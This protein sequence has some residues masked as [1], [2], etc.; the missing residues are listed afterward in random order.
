MQ[1]YVILGLEVSIPT[2]LAEIQVPT[3]DKVE[4]SDAH[5]TATP[6]D[7]A[8]SSTRP[9]Q[10]IPSPEKKQEVEEDVKDYW[11]E[12]L[13]SLP[14][15]KQEALKSMGL[16]QLESGSVESSFNDLVAIVNERQKECERKFWRISVRGKTIVLRNYTTS[17]ID[18]F[19]KTGDVAMP[20]APTQIALSWSIVKFVLQIPLYESEQMAALLGTTEKIVRIICRGQAYEKIYLNSK[21]QGPIDP[22]TKNLETGL[23]KIYAKSMRVKLRQAYNLARSRGT[24]FQFE[25]CKEQILESLNIYPRTIVVIYAMDECDSEKRY[26]LIDALKSFILE[27]K[28]TVKIFISS[29]PDSKIKSHLA[30]VPSVTISASNNHDDIEKFLDFELDRFA[31]DKGIRVLGRMKTEIMAKSLE[32]CQGMFQWAAMQVHQLKDCT[33]ATNMREM[34]GNLLDDLKKSYDKIWSQIEALRKPDQTLAKR[35]LRWTMASLRPLKSRELLLI[36]HHHA[37]N[38]FPSHLITFYKEDSTEDSSP[39][40]VSSSKKRALFPVVILMEVVK[41]EGI[42]SFLLFKFMNLWWIK[43]VYLAQDTENKMLQSR[44]NAFHGPPNNSNHEYRTWYLDVALCTALCTTSTIPFEHDSIDVNNGQYSQDVFDRLS[45]P[46]F[47]FFAICC[48]GFTD[49]LRSWR[50]HASSYIS[51]VNERGESPLGLASNAG[52]LTICQMLLEDGADLNLRLKVVKYLVEMGADVNMLLGEKEGIHNNAL[53]AAIASGNVETF[54]GRPSWDMSRQIAD[55]GILEFRR[56]ALCHGYAIGIAAWAPGVELLKQVLDAGAD[57]NQPLGCEF[58]PSVLAIKI[59]LQEVDS[60]K[61]LVQEARADADILFKTGEYGNALGA[62]SCFGYELVEALLMGGADVNMPLKNG[63]LGSALAAA[64]WSTNDAR[65]VKLLIE[66]GADVN[67]F[68]ENRDFSTAI[69]LVA[70]MPWPSLECRRREMVALLVKAPAE[71][72]PKGPVG[73]YGG[74]L[75]AAALFGE[76][77][78]VQYLIDAGADVNHRFQDIPYATALQAAQA[79]FSEKDWEWVIMFHNRF[80]YHQIIFALG[81]DGPRE[82]LELRSWLKRRKDRTACL[83][84]ENGAIA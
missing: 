30:S 65:I 63:G 17:I 44:L 48:F 31:K 59:E 79:D 8:G 80:V 15:D 83:L 7:D 72:N 37:A 32:K 23:V 45:P 25:Q 36:A 62:A 60:V 11:H 76:E 4:D 39:T 82:E 34:L 66:A 33:T 73:R 50:V 3:E 61:F 55:L 84:K 20:F 9:E 12:A 68:L 54:S 13:K 70:A 53:S 22:V 40:K 77:E 29:R 56:K 74:A 46:E 41:N 69:A 21:A 38:V 47:S 24:D 81:E 49:N 26:R 78:T 1:S 10:R 64:T 51:L 52:H 5:S 75:V 27:C 16:D 2:V 58:W 6:P 35:A 42:S 18:W 71:S 57:V 28:N 19:E 14:L 67:M 43:H